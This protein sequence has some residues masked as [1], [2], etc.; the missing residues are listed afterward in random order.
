MLAVVKKNLVLSYH[1]NIVDANVA[2]NMFPGSY[3]RQVGGDVVHDT[4]GARDEGGLNQINEGQAWR[5]KNS[6][7]SN[8]ARAQ[9]HRQNGQ[10]GGG[11]EPPAP[12]QGSPAG[13]PTRQSQ[14]EGGI[15]HN[16]N[17]NRV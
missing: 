3:I 12:D 7:N 5:Q 6:D 2:V 16:V 15:T 13:E 14:S 11:N 4:A 10:N 9:L 8:L 1:D 17:V